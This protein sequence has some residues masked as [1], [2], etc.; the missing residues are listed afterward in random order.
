MCHPTGWLCF[1]RCC[2]IANRG[3]RTSC[4]WWETAS[5]R[6]FGP[7]ADVTGDITP[8]RMR[9]LTGAST[10]P[11]GLGP[12]T[13]R[14]GKSSLIGRREDPMLLLFSAEL[15]LISAITPAALGG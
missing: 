5:D 15:P 8:T 10:A 9:A 6:C 14:T 12:E 1:A 7:I 3:R 2:A 11:E 13:F 4:A